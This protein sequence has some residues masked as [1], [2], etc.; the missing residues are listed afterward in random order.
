[1]ALKY[2]KEKEENVVLTEKVHYI[3]LEPGEHRVYV[4]L[5][6]SYVKRYEISDFDVDVAAV[7]ILNGKE[8]ARKETTKQIKPGWSSSAELVK[9]KG[10][11][12]NHAETPFWFINYDFKEVIKKTE[13]H[14]H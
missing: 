2:N 9:R 8:V 12:L 1:M 14:T 7:I 6:P 4:Y 13:S 10:Y 11:L 5:H 3:N